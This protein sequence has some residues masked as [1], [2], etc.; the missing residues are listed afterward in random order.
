MTDATIHLRVPVAQ[1]GRWIRA[2][3]AAGM[4][5]TDWITNAVEASMQRQ[6]AAVIIPD[7]VDFADLRLGRDADGMVTFDWQPLSR[8]CEASGL[9]W[10]LLRDGPED[11]V[12]GLMV[13]W[14]NAHRADGGDP[15]AVAEDLIAEVRAE[16]AAGQW[17]SF[18][19]GRA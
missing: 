11:N 4:R 1:K 10:E 9:A 19:P 14:Y 17:Y 6:L 3:R 13:A 18:E 12:S 5:L 7:D 2:S 16:D 15:D 8:I